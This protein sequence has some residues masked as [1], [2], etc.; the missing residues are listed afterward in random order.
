MTNDDIKSF[1]A[2]K[3]AEGI[4][5]SKIQDALLAEKKVKMTYM[6]LRM[7]ASEIEN[8]QWTKLDK[9]EPKTATPNAAPS[10]PAEQE[11]DAEPEDAIP[12]AGENDLESQAPD[13]DASAQ[14]AGKTTVE[15]SKLVKPGTVANGSV[16]FGSGVTADWYLD[17]YGRVG[18]GNPS[19]KPTEM[20]ITEFQ[21]ELQKLL[22]G[23]NG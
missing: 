14:I 19:G 23:V 5:L 8:A 10:A 17:Q 3:V 20:D 13:G 4:S 7:L 2:E 6:A 15:L 9:P 11:L 21:V 22:G 1:I 16:K 12:E 18:L